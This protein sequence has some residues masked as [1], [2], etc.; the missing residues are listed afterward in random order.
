M[1]PQPPAD[2]HPDGGLRDDIVR[3]LREVFGGQRSFGDAIAPPLVF[4]ITDQFASITAA[5][6]VAVM[7]G[8]AIAVFRVRRGTPITSTIAGLG[9]VAVAAALA[10][11]T[12]RSEDFF[13]PTILS[14]AALGFGTLI[15]MLARRPMAGWASHFL[16]RWPIGWY[17]R[18]DVRPA[19]T[20]VSMMWLTY[21]FG[22]AAVTW[23]L[24]AESNTAGLAVT[25]VALSWPTMVP[26][27]VIS[28][29]YGNGRLHRLAGPTVAEFEAGSGPPYGRQR[30][31]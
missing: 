19:Y 11:R 6:I 4:V 18:D 5:A 27:L 21:Y 25:R 17:W 20:E 28:Y 15:S 31:F 3:D 16:R 8:A 30:G 14:T 23:W 1:T 12:G 29:I 22:R 9:G 26:L 13:L 10:V 7:V 2:E 24:W